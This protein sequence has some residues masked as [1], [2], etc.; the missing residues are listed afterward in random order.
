MLLY[1]LT[2]GLSSAVKRYITGLQQLRGLSYNTY[3][4]DVLEY[5]SYVMLDF[6]EYL[7]TISDL[8]HVIT[9]QARFLL[10]F[11][12]VYHLHKLNSGWKLVLSEM[13][14]LLDYQEC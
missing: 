14:L 10:K 8:L 3:L 12:K 4:Q 11:D 5:F 13:S 1:I 6:N 9:L 2:A 7:N